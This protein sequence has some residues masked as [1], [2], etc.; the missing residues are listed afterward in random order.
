MKYIITILFITCYFTTISAQIAKDTN[1]P[2]STPIQDVQTIELHTDKVSRS[3]VVFAPSGFNKQRM[4]APTREQIM[5]L[6]GKAQFIFEDKIVEASTGTYLVIPAN[7]EH[8]V[9]VSGE[10]HLKLLVIQDAPE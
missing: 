2:Q 10:K 9:E 3:M 1:L 7:T 5:V 8:R 4:G 6:E